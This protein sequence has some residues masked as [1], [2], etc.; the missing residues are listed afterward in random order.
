MLTNINCLSL[1]LLAPSF[2]SPPSVGVGATGV[3]WGGVG[4]SVNVMKIRRQAGKASRHTFVI[5]ET[6]LAD[7]PLGWAPHLGEGHY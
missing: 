2:S 3:S 1:P 7:C 4:L 5:A 6:G